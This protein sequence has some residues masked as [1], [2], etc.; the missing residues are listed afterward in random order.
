MRQR[1][2]LQLQ[3]F[4]C[5]LRA[6]AAGA[7]GGSRR[8]A[9]HARSAPGALS[10]RTSAATRALSACARGLCTVSVAGES[11]SVALGGAPHLGGRP[12]GAA[13]PPACAAPCGLPRPAMSSAPADCSPASCALKSIIALARCGSVRSRRTQEGAAATLLMAS[14]RYRLSRGAK[15]LCSAPF[16]GPTVA[17][18]AISRALRWTPDQPGQVAPDGL[19]EEAAWC[20]SLVQS[21]TGLPT[22]CCGWEGRKPLPT[23]ATAA[24]LVIASPPARL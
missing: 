10:R 22:R 21:G 14:S 4:F 15:R 2:F 9:A 19:G 12:P 24:R 13:P 3:A 8:R 5:F 18:P 16:C 1:E 7:G 6:Q 23:G 20:G 17:V 11:C